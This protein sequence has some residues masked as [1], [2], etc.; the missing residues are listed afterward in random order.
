VIDGRIEMTEED[1]EL[2]GIVAAVSAHTREQMIEAVQE[3]SRLEAIDRGEARGIEQSAAEA[4]KVH[5]QAERKRR[6]LRWILNKITEAGEDGISQRDLH[7]AMFS[8]DRKFLSGALANHVANGLIRQLE[9]TT[10]WV[11]I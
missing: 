4:A 11:R 6:V 7:H 5:E 3:A 1:W 9:G 2:S 8:R 10:T